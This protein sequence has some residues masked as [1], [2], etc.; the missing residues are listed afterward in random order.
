MEAKFVGVAVAAVLVFAS[1]GKSASSPL[2]IPQENDPAPANALTIGQATSSQ[3]PSGGINVI[4]YTDT[5]GNGV[6]D[7][8]EPVIA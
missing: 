8:G 1:C 3:C 2:A 7:S 5:N 4:E 6:Y